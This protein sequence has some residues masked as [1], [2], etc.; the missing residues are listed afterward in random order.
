MDRRSFVRNSLFTLGGLTLP[1]GAAGGTGLLPT[2]ARPSQSAQ[3][4]IQYI[5]TEA[6]PFEI[7]PYHGASY[8]DTIPDT[9]D[10]AERCQLAINAITRATDPD[11]EHEIYFWV[12]LH[13]PP[14]MKHDF[15]DWCVLVEGI[16]ES[17]PL[18]RT[19][20]GSDFNADVDPVWM[21]SFL[22]SLGPD[23]LVY[24]P[25]N[26]RPWMRAGAGNPPVVEPIR[27]ADGTRT[28]FSDTSVSQVSLPCMWARALGT[29]SLY[30]TRDRNPMWKQAMRQMVDRA[31]ALAID[32][33]DYAF[34]P[35]GSFE[36]NAVESAS[37]QKDMFTG[38]GVVDV[39]GGRVIQGLAQCYKLTGYEPAATL[40]AKLTTFVRRHGRY[41]DEADG[42]FIIDPGQIQVGKD[43]YQ[44]IFPAKAAQLDA[45]L[46]TVKYGGHFHTHTIGLLSMIEYALATGDRELLAW[47]KSSFEWARTQAG[48]PVG[49]MPSTIVPLWPN[50]ES[51]EVGDM[52]QIALKLSKA[53]AGDY[54]D[55]VDRWTRNQFA[56]NQLT[57]TEWVYRAAARL[58]PEPVPPYHSGDHVPE[59]NIGA[60]AGWA[61][62][63]EWT[64]GPGPLLVMQCCNG[65]CNR[66]L[67]YLWEHILD[68]QD[69]R[70]RV[71]LLLNRASPWADLHS[72]IPYRGQVDLKIKR[73]CP[74]I[75]VRVPEWIDANRGDVEI[76]ANGKP[77]ATNWQ[78]R[79]VAVGHGRPGDTLT[80]N[81]PQ[82]LRKVTALLGTTT[83]S[84]ELK[85]NTV[86]SID[87]PGKIGPLYQ[88]AAYRESQV[89][90][91][92]VR[93]F[94]PET[95]IAW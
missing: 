53:G 77:R 11:L 78:G 73:E 37:D 82:P 46:A 3:P 72:S 47:T 50:C 43:T 89:P 67:Y 62:G 49:F 88:R 29:M 91:R 52:I 51:C 33:G 83:Y 64:V 9:L 21:K 40:A 41:Y 70:L 19:A 1:R 56:E 18:L 39:G 60:F 4:G 81:F 38:M 42:R 55:D 24:L 25:L 6:P 27:R 58:P 32:R 68:Y 84:L 16:M 65:N 54:W 12:S 45:E 17:L 71:N 75:W 87:P 95:E 57:S 66:A 15:S 31:A 35:R 34:Y 48:P 10:I 22:K 90:W 59:R 44:L 14:I 63:N 85:G 94:V 28:L 69:G 30:Y 86:V 79:Y 20:T 23:G 93:R 36:P 7:P 13:N 61:G 92:K 2:E 74:E 26:G 80:V 8:E 76:L 5:R